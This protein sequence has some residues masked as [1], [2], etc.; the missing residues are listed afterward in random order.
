MNFFPILGLRGY[1]IFKDT[2]LVSLLVSTLSSSR[3]NNLLSQC[4][5]ILDSAPQSNSYST[6][7]NVCIHRGHTINN[8]DFGI[9]DCFKPKLTHYESYLL[10][11]VASHI[12]DLTRKLW[13]LSFSHSVNYD[14]HIYR[15]TNVSN[16]RPLHRDCSRPRLK[17][18]IYLDTITKI[19]Q[20][21]YRIIPFT[22]LF[23]VKFFMSFISKYFS[24]SLS[25]S[26]ES[27]VRKVFFAD[28]ATLFITRQDALHGDLPTKEPF[29]RDVIVI[30][31]Y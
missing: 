18:F 17:A 29:S 6:L 31:F 15:Y 10:G 12:Y 11:Q 25:T 2:K 13:P 16:P 22:H 7:S 24:F 5:P 20:G 14:I 3:I 21:P 30:N 9:I 1:Y 23:L 27:L 26:F 8:Y 4:N 28:S 19:S